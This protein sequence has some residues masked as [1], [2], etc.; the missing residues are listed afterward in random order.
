M[1]L[2]LGHGGDA[3]A[4]E[5]G[6]GSSS[7]VTGR[8]ARWLGQ[9]WRRR[10]GLCGGVELGSM[11]VRAEVSVSRGDDDVEVVDLWLKSRTQRD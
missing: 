8:L 9:L 5:L 3:A 7:G 1:A 2:A 6:G 10:T 4:V 11:V